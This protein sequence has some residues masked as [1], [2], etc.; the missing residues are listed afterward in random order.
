MI[1]LTGNNSLIGRYLVPELLKSGEKI[2]C[3]DFYKSGDLPDSVEFIQSDLL[4][5]KI[6]RKACDGADTVIHLMDVNRTTRSGRTYM[7][8]I[9]TEGTRNLLSAADK[10]QVNRILF[11]SSYTVYGK[12]KNFPVRE[13]DR[14]K[15]MTAYGKDKLEAENIL[16][17]YAKKDRFNIT[18][19]RP[20]LTA[21][22]GVKSPTILLS[23]YMAL[24]MGNDNVLYLI[25]NGDSKFQLIHPAEIAEARAPRPSPARRGA[26]GR[27]AG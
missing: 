16:H 12:S 1:L 8:K 18:V 7:R 11:N 13:D 15:P 24:A 19:F 4:N 10:S 27:P 23:L 2:R 22:P 26:T 17:E 3:L 21:G 14:K 25:G 9:N 20:A 5:Q 6:L